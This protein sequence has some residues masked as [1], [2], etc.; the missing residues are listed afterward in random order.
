M[1]DRGG[2]M[3]WRGFYEMRGVSGRDSVFRVF[4]KVSKFV[5]T[6]IPLESGRANHGS[7]SDRIRP[8]SAGMGFGIGFRIFLW[9]EQT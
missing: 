4:V 3:T 2:M 6:W 1:G 7:D 8:E 5:V 9:L